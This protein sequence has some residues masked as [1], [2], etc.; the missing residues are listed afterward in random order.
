MCRTATQRR[1]CRIGTLL[2]R[3]AGETNGALLQE[4]LQAPRGE[5]GGEREAGGHS[6]RDRAANHWSLSGGRVLPGEGA[7][8]GGSLAA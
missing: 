7:P 5:G 1:V 8:A 6:P 4:A 2:E 3:K